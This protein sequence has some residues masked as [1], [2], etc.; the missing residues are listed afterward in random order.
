MSI[1]GYSSSYFLPEYWAGTPL[2][3]EKIIPLVDYILSMDYENSDSLARAFYNI[4]SKYKNVSDLPVEAV[5]AIIDENGYSYVK[6]LLGNNEES[7]RL[8]LTLMVLIHELK[9][10]KLGLQV[11]LNLL[12]RDNSTTVM[13]IVGTP[14]VDSAKNASGFSNSN[15]IVFDDFSTQGAVEINLRFG[16]FTVSSEQCIVSIGEKLFIGIDASGH[17]M[18]SLGTGFNGWD[19]LDSA[20]S[21]K[22][23]T[24]GLEYYVRLIYDGL[25]F[26]LQLSSDGK[27]WENWISHEYSEGWSLTG[28]S[29]Y[30]GVDMSD[31]GA[32]PFSGYINFS[33]FSVSADN[34]EITQWFE[35]TPVGDENTFIIKTDLDVTLVSTEFF[36]NFAHFVRQYVYP[37]LQAFIA[38]LEFN[39]RQTY[40][41]YVR[42]RLNYIASANLMN[43]TPFLVAGP[44]ET[45]EEFFVLNNSGDYIDFEVLDSGLNSED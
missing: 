31:S 32:A 10:T 42:T 19:I 33:D 4:T 26:A 30:L 11:V 8:L 14:L 45:L 23:L 34:I 16:G 36:S 17:L 2:Y 7:L 43:T 13:R 18:L 44:D 35:Q 5:S 3:G 24:K 37:T 40:I 41:P 12:R 15:Y 38:G 20:V 27:S 22:T 28:E 39:C 29:L 25:E 9:G 1:L 21:T 6:D